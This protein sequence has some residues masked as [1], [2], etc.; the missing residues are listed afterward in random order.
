[1]TAGRWFAMIEQ[2]QHDQLPSVFSS[3]C[4]AF[5]KHSGQFV[6][7]LYR[8][9]SLEALSK[10]QSLL[11]A[12]RALR[13]YSSVTVWSAQNSRSL[14][15]AVCG[16]L[17]APPILRTISAL[18]NAS[19][20]PRQ[21]TKTTPRDH[22]HRVRRQSTRRHQETNKNSQET[23]KRSRRFKE[24]TTGDHHGPRLRGRRENSV[25]HVLQFAMDRPFQGTR[26]G[27]A[28]L[29]HPSF[30]TQNFPSSVTPKPSEL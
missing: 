24:T 26:P 9:T 14:G 5:R 7:Q 21:T 8:N 19:G 25:G 12:F 27:F 15:E 13:L 2:T 23:T 11:K 4:A 28:V 6:L 18:E 20:G 16:G 10:P 22:H 17:E 30:V 1:M 29:V 3:I